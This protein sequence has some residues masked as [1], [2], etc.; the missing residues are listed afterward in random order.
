MGMPPITPF[1]Y[2]LI[3]AA[4]LP[5]LLALAIRLFYPRFAPKQSHVLISA[6][7][8]EQIFT[9]ADGRFPKRG[10]FGSGRW[11]ARAT[12]A[13]D[14]RRFTTYPLPYSSFGG[15][16]I[17]LMG[18]GEQVTIQANT[19]VDGT[20]V[21]IQT[22]GYAAQDQGLA[23]AEQLTELARLPATTLQMALV[24]TATI[25]PDTRGW[26]C[27]AC[28]G[29][30]RQDATTCK[31][32]HQPLTNQLAQLQGLLAHAHQQHAHPIIAAGTGWQCSACRGYVRQDATTCKHCGVA[33]HGPTT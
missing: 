15:L 20:H 1:G 33:L 28:Q 23:L 29:Y 5:L 21:Q 7:A 16:W 22:Q 8:P 31:H 9:L 10:V 3:S 11:W 13:P 30:V 14:V 32:C 2:V 18:Q 4:L 17:V 25:I 26:R 6:L 12:P 27:S 24:G 19:Q